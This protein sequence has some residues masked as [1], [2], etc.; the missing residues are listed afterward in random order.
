MK[1]LFFV[2]ANIVFF[3]P[4]RTVTI[5]FENLTAEAKSVANEGQKPFNLFLEEF[6]NKHG[7]EAP[8]F[9]KHFFY[10]PQ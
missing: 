3:V 1:G 5:E 8:L 4:K 2:L 10:L 7:E 6:Y 9:L